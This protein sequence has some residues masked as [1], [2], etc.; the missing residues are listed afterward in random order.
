MNILRRL[1]H[2]LTGRHP[3]QIQP[4][5]RDITGRVL[6]PW[7][8]CPICGTTVVLLNEPPAD[9]PESMTAELP[10]EQEEWLAAVDRELWAKEAV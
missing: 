3:W 5:D 4:A 10:P 7:R 2:A 6:G 8:Y 9:H 1:I